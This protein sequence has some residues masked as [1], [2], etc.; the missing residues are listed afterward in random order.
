MVRLT[1]FLPKGAFFI[2]IFLCLSVAG[3]VQAQ[4]KSVPGTSQTAV[5][6][7]RLLKEAGLNNKKYSE[8]VWLAEAQGKDFP[9]LVVAS[10]D[11]VVIG[12]IVAKKDSMP[13]SKEFL[14]KVAKLNHEYDF[15]KIGLDN[16]DDLFAR[17]ER[18]VAGMT[19]G[20]FKESFDQVVI[21]TSNVVVQLKPFLK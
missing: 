17:S 7:E 12:V 6:V 1:T 2:A 11:V 18:K 10:G 15:V 14:Y 16:E 9:V 4:Q 19:A 3:K 5:K 13:M 21:A 8:G 20:D